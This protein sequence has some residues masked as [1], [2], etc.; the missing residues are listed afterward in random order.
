MVIFPFQLINISKLSDGKCISYEQW[1]QDSLQKWVLITKKGFQSFPF[2][3]FYTFIITTYEIGMLV[4]GFN[5]S[6]LFAT[7]EKKRELKIYVQSQTQTAFATSPHTLT[8][9]IIFS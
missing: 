8:Y 5:R 1:Q 7:F 2:D 9:W 6:H 3:T 4:S